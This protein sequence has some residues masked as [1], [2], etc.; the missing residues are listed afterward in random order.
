MVVTQ[1]NSCSDWRKSNWPWKPPRLQPN[2]LRG[3]FVTLS[4]EEAMRTLFVT[5]ASA[6][7]LGLAVPAV[8]GPAPER[9]QLAQAQSSGDKMQSDTKPG[10]SS[11]TMQRGSQREGG[12]SATTRSE[13][14]GSAATRSEGGRSSMS[15]STESSRTS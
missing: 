5:L 2:C 11:G 12:G 1:I 14:S 13:G 10:S 9:M 6:A 3:E 8:A 4:L 7:A 15:K